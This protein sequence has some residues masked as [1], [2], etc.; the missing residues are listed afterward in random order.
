MIYFPVIGCFIQRCRET[1]RE[2]MLRALRHD[3]LL[4]NVPDPRLRLNNL[5]ARGTTNY[6]PMVSRC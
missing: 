4:A 5:A 6:P 3:D 1:A 2:S